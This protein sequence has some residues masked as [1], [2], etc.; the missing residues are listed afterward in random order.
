MSSVTRR[1]TT[2]GPRQLSGDYRIRTDG[3]RDMG[4]GSDDADVAF[5]PVSLAMA[6]TRAVREA[7]GEGTR[8]PSM[9]AFT[10][11]MMREGGLFTDFRA[12][13]RQPPPDGQEREW[14][15]GAGGGPR[16]RRADTGAEALGG[17][18]GAEAPLARPRR[19][20]SRVLA[21]DSQ[22]VKSQRG[23]PSVFS[24]AV[25]V[26]SNPTNIPSWT[27]C[28]CSRAIRFPRSR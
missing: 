23:A 7:I 19:Q 16:P 12:R 9:T 3:C 1:R 2:G 13:L 10:E 21:H 25:V 11:R 6:H 27:P 28:G 15:R 18:R 26:A 14:G 22:R 5:L 8:V 24:T 17:P 20:T 4:I